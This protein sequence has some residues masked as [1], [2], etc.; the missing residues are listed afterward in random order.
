MNTTIAADSDERRFSRIPFEAITLLYFHPAQES[1]PA[2]LLDISLKGALLELAHTPGSTQQNKI[3][4]MILEL[5]RS[6]E[7]IVMEARVAHHEGRLIGIECRHIDVDS[8]ANLRQLMELN[9]GN[10]ELLEREMSEML[11]I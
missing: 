9:T 8:M 3:C 1:H 7:R 2:R 6:G 10:P 4:R 5:G 11:K